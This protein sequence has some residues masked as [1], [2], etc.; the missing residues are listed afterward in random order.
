MYRIK[1]AVWLFFLCQS[2]VSVQG[3]G[4]SGVFVASF[5]NY[6]V[7]HKVRMNFFSHINSL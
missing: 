2:V 4:F 5:G 1:N 6:S 3:S 7:R